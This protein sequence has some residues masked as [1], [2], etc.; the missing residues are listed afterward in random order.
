MKQEISQLLMQAL[1]RLREQKTLT[2][3]E[4]ETVHLE[5][6]RDSRHGDFAT[7][8]ALVLAK[9]ARRPAL[10]LAQAILEALPESTAFTRAEVA[11][12]GFINFY[13]APRAFLA[14]IERIL[15]EG[16][17]YGG[18][19]LG[20]GTRVLIEFVSANPTGPLHV[21]HGRGAAYGAAL[22][23]LL[24]EAGYRVEREYYVNDAGRQMDIL[25]LSVWLR[26]LELGGESIEFPAN[27]YRGEYVNAI[28]AGLRAE[29]GDAYTASAT[30]L[31]AVATDLD[32]ETR[33]DALIQQARAL[34]GESRFGAIHEYGLEKV[35]DGIERDLA[36]FGVVYD[37]WF[38]ERQLI[39]SRDLLTV[40][41]QLKR[42]GHLYLREGAWWFN[43]SAFG[44]EKDR[45]VIRENGQPTYF[46]SDIAYH[47]NKLE[48][49]FSV[50]IDI[51]GADHH[52][53]IPRLKGVLQATG[54]EPQRLECLLVQFVS[55]YRGQER[56][57]MSTRAGEFVTLRELYQEVGV[58]AT[59]FFYVMRRCEQ[60]LDFDLELAKSHSAD[61]PVYYVQYAH[62]RVCSVMRHL[63]EK[64]YSWDQS[65][66]ND[67]LELL[68]EAEEKSVI[69]RLSQYP[70]L[71]NAAALSREPHQIAQYLR[72]LA[73][74]FH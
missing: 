30:E 46:A 9:Q 45:V 71:V 33:L 49:G 18:S 12:P 52:G 24:A 43:A 39:E 25:A 57:P 29:S 19:Q 15:A 41:E 4:P 50:L 28:A 13:L 23:N 66:G 40:A 11:G 54:T 31:G 5:P 8:I 73:N 22:A 32:P 60:H 63:V 20:A 65:M 59:R 42:S 6:A 17:R 72:E 44:D 35:L 37:R 7:N 14:V 48:R 56:V 68:V 53:Y 70:D 21:G 51:W 69:K 1:K 27:G 3:A 2:I 62:A 47:V 26:Y 10:E 16:D 55:L 38:S 36:E 61:N 58:D 74:D 64:G 34:L 67:H